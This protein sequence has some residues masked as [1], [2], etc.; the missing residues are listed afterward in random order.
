MKKCIA[1]IC[2]IALLAILPAIQAS[3]QG[4][5]TAEQIKS[6]LAGGNCYILSQDGSAVL[7]D[8]GTANY[9]DTILE[10]CRQQ[11]VRLIVITHGHYDHVQNAAFLAKALGVPVAMHPADLPLLEN[12]LAEPILAHRPLGKVMV[13]AIKLQQWPWLGKLLSWALNNEIP[14]FVPDIALDDGF[15]LAPYGVDARVIV[16]PGH[17]RGSVGVVAGSDLLVGDA[18]MNILGPSEA[19]HYVDKTAMEASA[20][21]VRGYEGATVWMGH[22]GAIHN[23]G[24]PH[25]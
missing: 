12:I 9:R 11:N 24:A 3:A 21:K 2:A 20:A 19:L 17:T 1:I 23:P 6:G 10:K 8:T 15:S 18:M 4:T 13:W 16:L 22:G 7:V 25:D 14:A 5:I